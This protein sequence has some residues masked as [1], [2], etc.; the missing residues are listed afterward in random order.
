VAH[1]LIGEMRNHTIISK[2]SQLT[3]RGGGR[4]KLYR[5]GHDRDAR[6]RQ[7]DD[8]NGVDDYGDQDDSDN[9]GDESGEE[10]SEKDE[11][12]EDVSTSM[13]IDSK[14]N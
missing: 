14:Y 10:D 7:L 9:G 3:F 12:T 4:V 5:E 8:D 13:I 11:D 6:R 1:S 2:I